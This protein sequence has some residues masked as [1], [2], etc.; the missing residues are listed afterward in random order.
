[1][2]SREPVR[3]DVLIY[4]SDALCDDDDDDDDIVCINEP[5][6]INALLFIATIEPYSGIIHQVISFGRIRRPISY[7]A[8]S[9]DEE[10]GRPSL[11]R[12]ALWSTEAV[13]SVVI[14]LAKGDDAQR[15]L[16]LFTCALF[17]LANDAEKR[18]PRGDLGVR[19]ASL[20]PRAS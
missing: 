5:R 10:M 2:E 7:S 16:L 18:E 15:H 13:E 6:K 17:T 9:R 19:R 8:F 14:R 12:R 11:L 20:S 4:D 1:M 3:S